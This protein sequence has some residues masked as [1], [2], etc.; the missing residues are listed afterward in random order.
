LWSS[1]PSI[2]VAGRNFFT[3]L[4]SQPED[5]RVVIDGFVVVVFEFVMPCYFGFKLS[6]PRCKRRL[7]RRATSLGLVGRL[8]RRSTLPARGLRSSKR[9]IRSRVSKFEWNVA[10]LV[11]EVVSKLVAM[12]R[13]VHVV[14]SR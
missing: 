3:F 2:G 7:I 14:M 5:I 4:P 10:R 6:N 11:A 9:A 12:V 1:N 8:L 13:I